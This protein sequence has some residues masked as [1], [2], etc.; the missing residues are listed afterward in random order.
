MEWALGQVSD[1]T[2]AGR[3]FL[4]AEQMSPQLATPAML[5]YDGA[6]DDFEVI[7]TSSGVL[8]QLLAPQG[9][10]DIVI[11][12]DY[13]Y[14]LRFYTAA[15]AGVK[16]GEG[17]YESTGEP[18]LTWTIENPDASP[19][20]YNRLRLTKTVGA[21]HTMYDYVWDEST[22]TWTL[23]SGNGLKTETKQTIQLAPTQRQEIRTITDPTFGVVSKIS[24]TYQTFPRMG[25]MR[26]IGGAAKRPAPAG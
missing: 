25:M 11:I 2:R 8:R 23:S 17:L 5:F 9:L 19:T 6:S 24:T 21:A 12:D 18:F 26:L 7:R 16:N 10:A 14:G 4:A 20:V 22:Q 15:N 1:G 3:L 13:T